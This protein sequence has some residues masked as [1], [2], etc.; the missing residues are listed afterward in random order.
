M[1][2]EE[3][4]IGLIKKGKSFKWLC[5]ELGYSV[6]WIYACIEEQRPEIISKIKKLLE[7]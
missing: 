4:K 7:V 3:I 2:Y 6:T 5:A 1:T